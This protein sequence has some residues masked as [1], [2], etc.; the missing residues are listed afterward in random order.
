M[1]DRNLS[2][3]LTVV[4]GLPG[5]GKSTFARQLIRE[6]GA[7]LIGRDELNAALTN[8]RNEAIT[9]LAMVALAETLLR[10]GLNVVV[11]AWNLHPIDAERWK[12]ITRSTGAGLVWVH[13][14]T[15]IDECVRRD[16]MRPDP[17]GEA[18]VRLTALQHAG[19]LQEL[20][21]GGL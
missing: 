11:D 21:G 6:T 16:S 17:N 7:V 4:S 9:T 14:P 13:I 12:E 18:A 10:C 20:A 3:R 19:R 8:L 2:A 1:G 5:A 15:P